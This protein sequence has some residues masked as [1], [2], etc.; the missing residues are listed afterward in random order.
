MVV[1]PRELLEAGD[2]NINYSRRGDLEVLPSQQP[3]SKSIRKIESVTAI[4]EITSATTELPSYDDAG[5]IHEL[6]NISSTDTAQKEAAV[7]ATEVGVE[8]ESKI[9]KKKIKK[10]SSFDGAVSFSYKNQ[11]SSGSR[12]FAPTAAALARMRTDLDKSSEDS[13]TDQTYHHQPTNEKTH[14]ATE[15]LSPT[16]MKK[17]PHEHVKR[18][19]PNEHVRKESGASLEGSS[20]LLTS[21]GKVK[22]VVE[23]ETYVPKKRKVC[24]M[25]ICFVNPNL[26]LS[27]PHIPNPTTSY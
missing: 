27:I 4:N 7:D 26:L 17:V 24:K 22:Q 11:T 21:I 15:V 9:E 1:F 18:D 2:N 14:A 20:R 10:V 5:M 16:T 8:S 19:T 12:L 25:V 13:E 6:S 23:E 3:S